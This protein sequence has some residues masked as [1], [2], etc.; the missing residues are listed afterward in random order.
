MAT[1]LIFPQIKTKRTHSDLRLKDKLGHTR[2]YTEGTFELANRVLWKEIAKSA[3]Y[4]EMRQ[5]TSVAI[6]RYSILNN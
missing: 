3:K 5:Q 6:Q 1:Q 2:R 4:A